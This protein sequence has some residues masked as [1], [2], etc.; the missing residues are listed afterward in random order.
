MIS[1]IVLYFTDFFMSMDSPPVLVHS[2]IMDNEEDFIKLNS[3]FKKKYHCS[4]SFYVRTPGR[5]NLIGEHIDY[6]GYA[7]LPMAIERCILMAVA[8]DSQPVVTLTNSDSQYDSFCCKWDEMKI[9]KSQSKW[10]NYVLAGILGV[11]EHAHFHSIKGMKLAVHGNIPPGA[12]L[13]SSSAL[14]CAAAL[15]TSHLNG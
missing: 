6:C 4:P 9:D 3:T 11:Q 2:S 15:A 7:V 14:V 13:S 8:E 1:L 10:Y 5:V 12:G